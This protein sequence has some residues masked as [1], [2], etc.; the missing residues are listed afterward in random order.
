MSTSGAQAAAFFR[1]IVRHPVV[2]SV[3]DDEGGP[4]WPSASGGQVVPYWSSEVRVKRA[5]AI[6]GARF[7]AVSM[8]LRH[9][10]QV[11][12]PDLA[13]GRLRVGINWSGPRLTGWDFTVAEVLNRLA[14]ALGEPPYDR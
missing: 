8:P 6:W 12:L 5:V 13:A 7:R 2:W 11:E 14:H 9:W 10:Q 3:R 4:T 1:E